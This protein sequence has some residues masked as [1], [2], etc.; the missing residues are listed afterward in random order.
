MCIV[1]NNVRDEL[2]IAIVIDDNGTWSPIII[3]SEVSKYI[4]YTDGRIK[5]IESNKYLSISKIDRSGYIQVFL[6]HKGKKYIFNL[7]RL[8]AIAFIPNQNN[9]P[10]VNHI[11]GK[12]T[13]NELT[14]LEWVTN[15]EN[16]IHA[17][18][19]NLHEVLK[20]ENNPSNK[21]SENKIR[22]VCE[23]IESNKYSITKISK[24]TNVNRYTIN[25]I[26]RKKSWVDISDE[27]DI[28]KFNKS[29]HIRLN[30]NEINKIH[31]LLVK[32]YRTKDIIKYVN[33]PHGSRG[34]SIVNHYRHKF[35]K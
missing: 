22:Q 24:M 28:S 15:S 20:G 4:I 6:S 27:Y 13:D 34:Y 26:L 5:N 17:Y 7:H 25:D 11:N 10:Q 1:W 32:G 23:L 16:Q 18:K 30:D 21:Y 14:N 19:Y 3:N 2:I 31:D 35:L 33:L 29:D 12:K 8:L 9:K